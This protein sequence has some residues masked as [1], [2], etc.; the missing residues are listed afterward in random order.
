MQPLGDLP[1]GQ[2]I[3]VAYDINNNSKAVGW[4]ASEN[5]VEAFI[6]DEVNGIRP[7]DHLPDGSF[8]AQANAINNL[9]QVTGIALTPQGTRAFVWS[10]VE[11][12]IILPAPPGFRA[13]SF[14]EDINDRGEV[15]GAA[16]YSCC[17]HVAFGMIWDPVND[18]RNINELLAPGTAPQHAQIVNCQKI[19]NHGQILT[20]SSEPI[21]LTPYLPGDLDE[22]GVVDLADLARLMSRYGTAEPEYTDG[23]IDADGDV[24]FRDLVWLLDN[25]GQMMP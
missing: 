22:D 4:S 12:L 1:G 6:W 10:E 17:P 2:T 8:A 3:S 18:M 16:G 14:G 19:N 15:S 9:D 5:Y 7:L 23:D 20:Y 24:D 21:I 25:F 11:G 13:L